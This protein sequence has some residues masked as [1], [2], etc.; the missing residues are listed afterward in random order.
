MD[1]S[2]DLIV[3]DGF[4]FVLSIVL[5]I[6]RCL[7]RCRREQQIHNTEQ[8]VLKLSERLHTMEEKQ[9]D[10]LQHVAPRAEEQAMV[11][12][13]HSNAENIA[14][15]AEEVRQLRTAVLETIG[16]LRDEVIQLKDKVNETNE[17]IATLTDEI[18]TE[19]Q[20]S[21]GGVPA[22]GVRKIWGTYKFTKVKKV[23]KTIAR[24]TSVSASDLIITKKFSN[25]A[26][27]VTRW[28]FAVTA[29]ES[30]LLKLQEEWHSVEVETQ[31]KL[32]TETSD[33]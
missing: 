21:R 20:C 7:Q 25:P 14:A 3:C 29:E 2:T 10:I 11:R 17:Q 24:L 30:V 16:T 28:W 15:L 12:E 8:T 19:E 31:W 32:M 18:K 22:S 5:A 26:K 9:D 23:E 13:V 6:Y 1:L 27:Y 33:V 4:L